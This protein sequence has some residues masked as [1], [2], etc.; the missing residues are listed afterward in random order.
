MPERDVLYAGG[1]GNAGR[2][3]GGGD[4]CCRAEGKRQ[5]D[6]EPDK[7]NGHVVNASLNKP[8]DQ[9]RNA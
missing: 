5:E 7:R 6:E 3:E 8:E 4:N 2:S 9:Y 1:G